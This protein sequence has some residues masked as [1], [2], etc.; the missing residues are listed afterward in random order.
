MRQLEPDHVGRF[1]DAPLPSTAVRRVQFLQLADTLEIAEVRVCRE[2]HLL[3]GAAVLLLR[4]FKLPELRRDVLGRK[5]IVRV[6]L[7]RDVL[8]FSQQ[9]SQRF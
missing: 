2:L 7:R 8:E 9:F 3:F 1:A 5:G 4:C 6:R